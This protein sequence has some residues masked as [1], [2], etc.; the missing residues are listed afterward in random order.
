MRFSQKVPNF[1]ENGDSLPYLKEANSLSYS[2]IN[3][4]SPN[5]P[6][7]LPLDPSE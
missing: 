3:Y 1:I 7:P 6:T 4:P 2:E 5:F